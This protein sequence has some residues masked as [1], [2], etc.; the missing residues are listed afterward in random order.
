MSRNVFLTVA[1]LLA[2]LPCSAE[3]NV[4]RTTLNNGMHVII[5]RNPLAPAVTVYENYRVGGNE[6]PARFPGMAHAQEHMM[7]RGCS[8]LSGDQTA[9]I[10]AQL[11]GDG[12]ADTQQNLT[13]YYET[14]PAHDLNI[15]LHVDSDCMRSATDLSSQWAQERPAIEQEVARDLSDPTYKLITRMN[16][17]MFTGTPYEHDP[18]GTQSSFDAT[19]AAMLKK[20]HEQWYAPNNATLIIAGDV[21]PEAAIASIKNLYGAIPSRSL[22]LRPQIHL[23]PVKAESFTL[24]SDYPYIISIVAFR[25]PGSDSPDYAAATIL[26]DV[27]SSQRGAIYQLVADG[28][29]LDAGFQMAETYRKASMGMAYVVLPTNGNPS[30]MDGAIRSLLAQDAEHGVKA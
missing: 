12:D 15:A 7:F 28:K 24:P 3:P 27:L 16:R 11:G 25:M 20:F 5:I 26:A 9:A 23:Q 19:T 10:F 8:G 29:V 22:P 1:L 14:V 17:D 13:Q 2:V 18:L 6:T 21:Q 30:T 4:T